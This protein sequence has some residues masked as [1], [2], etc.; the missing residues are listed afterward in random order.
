M[1]DRPGDPDDEGPSRPI[2]RPP[3]GDEDPDGSVGA[4]FSWAE[5]GGGGSSPPGE[6]RLGS[7]GG[8]PT[9]EP[10]WAPGSAPGAGRVP[11]GG[12][13]GSRWGGGWLPVAVVSALIGAGVAA[14]VSALT[15]S[16]PNPS[17]ITT[18]K[19]S[20]A[21]PGPAVVGGADIPKLV[22]SVLPAVVSIDVKTALEEAEGTGM[23][24]SP[25]GLVVTN[26]HV[27]ALAAEDGG[28]LTITESGSTSP[29]KA[30]VVGTD[31]ADDIALVRIDRASGLKTV[32]FGDSTK[33]EVGDA[34]VAIGNALGLSQ[35]SPTVTSGIVSAVGRTVAASGSSEGSET[36][37]DLIQT[38]AA[39]NPGNSGGPLI[40]SEGQVIGMNTA[41]AG[42]TSDGTSAQNIGFAIPSAEIETLLPTLENGNAAVSAP[43]YMGVDIATLTPQLRAEYG[44]TPKAGAVIISVVPGGPADQAGLE[45]A[46]VIVAIGPKPVASVSDLQAA[47]QSA[48][49]GQSIKVTY[50]RGTSRRTV[51]VTLVSASQLQNIETQSGG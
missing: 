43:G 46:D 25:N 4:P 19:E 29:V 28:Q 10:V 11:G 12:G 31:P 44:F 16:A 40:D 24:I 14:G 32:T 49:A 27:V 35:G 17:G 13:A 48:R 26:Y 7:L 18:I 42:T 22:A 6:P 15:R 30:A 50:Y 39:I 38:D 8:T 37:S 20:S 21:A 5:P 47:V 1:D 34:V 9:Q 41:V 23:I 36:L 33:A 3:E 2:A 51:S 45:L